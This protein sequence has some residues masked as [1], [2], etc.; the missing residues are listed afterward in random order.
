MLTRLLMLLFSLTHVTIECHTIT[1]FHY[2]SI[3]R[4][5]A[6][7]F[8]FDALMLIDAIRYLRRLPQRHRRATISLLIRCLRYF[9]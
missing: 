1:L 5:D 9:H 7:P 8:R 2:F 3:A 6:T 4:H